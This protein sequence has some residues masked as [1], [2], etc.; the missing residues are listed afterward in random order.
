MILRNSITW[1]LT[2]IFAALSTAVLIAI[3][4]IASLS[5]ENHFA[6][7]DMEEINGKLELIQNA[8]DKTST[9]A[10]IKNLPQK[11]NDALV[12]HHALLVTVYEPSGKILYSTH[13]ADFP[14]DIL[15]THPAHYKTK[16]ATLRKWTLNQRPYRGLSVQMDTAR[17]LAAPLNVAIALDIEHHQVFIQRFQQSLWVSLFI[18]VLITVVLGWIAVKRGL[19]PVR[20]FD[21]IAS[22]VSASR[23][24]ERIPVEVL[25]NELVALGL[26]FNSMLQRLEDSFQRLSD[27]SSDIAHELRTP[28]SN[29]MT[30]TQV[31]VSKSRTA[32][33]YQEILYSNLEEYDHLSRMISDMLFLAKAD[34]GLIVPNKEKID[35]AQEAQVVIDFFEPLADE[36]NVKIVFTGNASIVGDKLMMRRAISNLLSNAIRH[37]DENQQININL[38]M[39]ESEQIQL[40]IDN[41][42]EPITQEHLTK[43]F[44]RFY[45]IDPSRQRNSEGSGLG[46]AITKSI[47]ESHGGKISATYFN[48][49]IQIKISF[50]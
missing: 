49:I 17:E 37:T 2:L 44:D 14:E 40:I 28:I 31:A 8:F 1:R 32:D 21:K 30:Q 41:P 46:L 11:L 42:C 22:R 19:A 18:G 38:G 13:A 48:G 12:G 35:L 16:A 10:D 43:I 20:D 23:L 4:T 50:K 47:I 33:E 29:L 6:E 36:K 15:E 25:P 9:T 3:G 34:N 27:F 39:M 26:S 24:D 45:R 7:E 5:V